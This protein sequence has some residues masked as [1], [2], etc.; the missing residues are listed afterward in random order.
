MTP[1]PTCVAMADSAMANVIAINF[2]GRVGG[3]FLFFVAEELVRVLLVHERKLVA[4]DDDGRPVGVQQAVVLDLL[5]D[6]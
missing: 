2:I 3:G 1:N 6:T 5:R 4:R